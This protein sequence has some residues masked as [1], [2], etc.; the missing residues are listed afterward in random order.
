MV[1]YFGTFLQKGNI[2]YI[3]NVILQTNYYLKEN[4]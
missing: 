1:F 3:Y 2:Y 4:K